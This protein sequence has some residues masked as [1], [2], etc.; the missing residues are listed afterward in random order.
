MLLYPG[1]IHQSS[2]LTCWHTQ[3]LKGLLAPEDLVERVLDLEVR[4]PG[5]T[6]TS[7]VAMDESHNAPLALVSFSYI[8]ERKGEDWT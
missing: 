3:G 2:V 1:N 4:R 8:K 7:F 6:V 5:L